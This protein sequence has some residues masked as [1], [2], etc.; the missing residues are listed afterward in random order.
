MMIE[1]AISKFPVHFDDGTS[2][3]EFLN[4]PPIHFQGCFGDVVILVMSLKLKD[5]VPSTTPITY[6][7]RN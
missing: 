1:I 4:D 6:T 7:P 2:F 3:G 5:V